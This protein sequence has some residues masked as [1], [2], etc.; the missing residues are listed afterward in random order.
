MKRRRVWKKKQQ[1]NENIAA[2][3]LTQWKFSN[4]LIHTFKGVFT[5]ISNIAQ[6]IFH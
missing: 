1:K 6:C 2:K 4:D 3:Q 5:D